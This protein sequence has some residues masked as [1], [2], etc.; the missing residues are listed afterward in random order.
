ME[1][2]GTFASVLKAT[3]PNVSF[4]H[5]NKSPKQINTFIFYKK[6][7]FTFEKLELK[8]MALENMNTNNEKMI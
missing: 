7:M 3:P 4:F 8:F 1:K 5:P 6:Q 2:K